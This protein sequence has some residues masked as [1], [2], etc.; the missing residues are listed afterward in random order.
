MPD[1]PWLRWCDI[2]DLILNS[3]TKQERDQIEAELDG[4]GPMTKAMSRGTLVQRALA[5]RKAVD[6]PTGDDQNG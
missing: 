5:R 2:D 4:C 6:S 1:E 3:L